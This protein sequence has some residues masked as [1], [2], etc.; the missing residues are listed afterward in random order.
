MLT[1]PLLAGCISSSAISAAKSP[2]ARVLPDR[3][4]VE[5]AAI[6]KDNQLLIYLEGS[7]TNSSKTNRFTLRIPL[8]QLEDNG[9]I[10]NLVA[11]NGLP[12]AVIN[13][14]RHE[15]YEGWIFQKRLRDA[16]PV[17]IGLPIS[18][19]YRFPDGDPAYRTGGSTKLLPNSTQAL[20]QVRMADQIEFIYIDSSDKR[21]FTDL[22]V[23]PAMGTP[24]EEPGYYFLLPVTVPLDIA[25]SPIQIPIYIFVICEFRWGGGC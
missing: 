19:P 21:A 11:T 6:S 8:A 18:P 24:S 7:I 12:S 14:P 5:K 23:E 9:H 25:T 3:V 22:R 15:L 2:H 13:V 17:A 10:I 16:K 4:H 1:L 20:C